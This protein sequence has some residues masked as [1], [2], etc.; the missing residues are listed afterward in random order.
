MVHPSSDEALPAIYNLRDPALLLEHLEI[1]GPGCDG[2]LSLPDDFLSRHSLLLQ[3][4]R[5]KRSSFMLI[6]FPLPNQSLI[7]S[8]GIADLCERRA[9]ISL[10]RSSPTERFHH[11]DIRSHGRDPYP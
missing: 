4:L 2:I 3:H 9:R 10:L 5:L 8:F 6:P 11:Y 7:G 1:S